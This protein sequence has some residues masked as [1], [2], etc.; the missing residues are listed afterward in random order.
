M[1]GA[2]RAAEGPDTGVRGEVR[3]GVGCL[4]GGGKEGGVRAW[5]LFEVTARRT[6]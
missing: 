6:R 4:R 1:G 3:G 2:V 5:T